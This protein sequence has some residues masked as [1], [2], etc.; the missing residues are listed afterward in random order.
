MNI[1][2]QYRLYCRI[3]IGI[4]IIVSV[5]IAWN[6]KKS[7][8]VPTAMIFF[9]S[10]SFCTHL[11]FLILNYKKEKQIDKKF[12]FIKVNGDRWLGYDGFWHD[13]FNE[14]Y[15]R[16]LDQYYKNGGED[17]GYTSS[18]HMNAASIVFGC[19]AGLIAMCGELVTFENSFAAIAIL[20]AFLVYAILRRAVFG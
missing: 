2:K 13:G 19:Y 14:V 3:A 20:S 8:D 12:G 17:F 1:K 16:K 10:F 7:L 5:I 15:G 4:S 6:L 9:G 18:L 11:L